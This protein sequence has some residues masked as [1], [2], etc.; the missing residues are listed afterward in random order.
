MNRVLYGALA[1]QARYVEAWRRINVEL[2][3]FQRFVPAGMVLS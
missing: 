3:L 2:T 1:K